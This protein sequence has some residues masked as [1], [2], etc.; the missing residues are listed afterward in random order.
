MRGKTVK[1]IRKF[2]K[3]LIENTPEEQRGNKTEKMMYKE[4]KT[5]WYTQGKSG[6][7]FVNFVLEGNLSP[8]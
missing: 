6:Q 4:M 2:V 8:K 5:L 3:T 1:K 7:K